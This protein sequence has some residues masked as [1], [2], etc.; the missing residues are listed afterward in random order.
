M[1][2]DIAIA[3]INAYIAEQSHEQAKAVRRKE[4]AEKLLAKANDDIAIITGALMGA[5]HIYRMLMSDELK[6]SMAEFGQS[7]EGKNKRGADSDSAPLK[8]TL[9]GPVEE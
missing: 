4:H 5:E 2:N 6:T 1:D 7:A 3:V 9:A 8:F